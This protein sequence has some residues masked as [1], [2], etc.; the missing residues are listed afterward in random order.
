MRE[1]SAA[2]SFYS[3]RLCVRIEGF[4]ADRLLNRACEAGIKIHDLKIL[5]DTEAEGWI[6][7][8][9]LKKLRTIGKSAYRI[10]VIS[11]KGPR[12]RA[13]QLAGKPVTVVGILAACMIVAVQSLF[14]AS[15]RIDGYQAIPEDSLRL[16]LEQS[17]IYEGVYRPAIDWEQA[18]ENLR[19][20]FPQ[21]TWIQLAYDGRTVLLNVAESSRRI[22]SQEAGRDSN[23]FIP[24]GEQ[25][26]IYC[27]VVA[28]CSGYVEK[29]SALWGVPQ[30][31]AGDY[32]EEGAV[33]ISGTVPMEPTT[34]EE[35]W[36]VE[37]YVRAQ[38]E[39][40]ALV[41]YRITFNQERYI[42]DT[43]GTGENTLADY[44]EKTEEEALAT[45]KQQIRLWIKENLPENAEIVNESLN[46]SRKNNIIESGVTLEVRR[47]IGIEKEIVVGQKNSDN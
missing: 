22:L 47:Q 29:I 35:D 32:V 18:R 5:S 38:G 13:V 40:T 34:F 12:H 39:I 28:D 21:L 46:F 2:W 43:A 30:V 14:V 27:D 19:T 33:L 37:Y 25:E 4:R 3:H 26:Q 44:R 8:A 7:A 20:T 16:C 42:Q 11:G 23:L 10:T 24:S 9:D 45:V 15:I 1:Q 41:P 17:G 36:P 31:G 6:A